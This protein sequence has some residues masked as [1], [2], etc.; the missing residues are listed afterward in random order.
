MNNKINEGW[1]YLINSPKWHYVREGRTLCNRF[2]VLN[3]EF[4]QGNDNSVDNCKACKK[5]LAKIKAEEK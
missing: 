1:T 3:T 4:E 5:K 2:M